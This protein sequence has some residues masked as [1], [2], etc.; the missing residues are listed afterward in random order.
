MGKYLVANAFVAAFA[1]M[2]AAAFTV[3]FVPQHGNWWNAAVQLAVLG[4]FVPLIYAVNI[5]VVP[6]FA[7]REWTSLNALRV[8]VSLGIA[9]AWLVYGSHLLAVDMLEKMGLAATLAAGLLFFRNVVALFRQA[10]PTKPA[11]PLPYP[12]QKRVDRIATGFTRISG[13]YLLFGMAIGLVKSVWTPGWG[14]WDLVWAHTMLIGFLLSMVSGVTYHVLTRW[15]D[16]HWKSIRSIQVHYWVSSAGLPVMLLALAGDFELLFRIAGPL[17]ALALA[18]FLFNVLPLVGGLPSTTRNAWLIA[19]AFLVV[20]ISLGSL[21]AFDPAIGARLRMAHAEINLF[22]WGGALVSGMA[23]YLVPRFAG[24]PLR[25]PRLVGLQLSLLGLGVVTSAVTLGVRSYRQDVDLLIWT[26]QLA[27]A[28]AFAL[29][30]CIVGITF[31][32]AKPVPVQMVQLRRIVK[33]I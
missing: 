30:A 2:A 5:R 15:T 14:R 19:S 21:F 8:Q 6:V 9:G 28:F 10:V 18:I 7:R 24:A 20:G 27:I 4:G 11:L 1:A 31:H 13:M 23:I 16:R 26:G 17:Q 33:P 25:W 29:M 22:G 3:A 12:D 32:S